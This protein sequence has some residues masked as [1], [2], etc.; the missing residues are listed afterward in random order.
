M[1]ERDVSLFDRLDARRPPAEEKT[2]QQPKQQAEVLLGWLD[3]WPKPILTLRDLRNFAPRSIRNKEIG[4]HATRILTAHR[5]LTPLAST[6]SQIIPH[7]L[8]PTR[9]Q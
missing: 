4:L 9:S 5:H 1:T 2:A 3:K 8:S 6:K 7:P